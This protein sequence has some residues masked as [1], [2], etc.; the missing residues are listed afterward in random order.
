MF[1]PETTSSLG[2]RQ[3][4]KSGKTD[5]NESFIG[6]AGTNEK[7]DIP[8]PA[9]KEARYQLRVINYDTKMLKGSLGTKL[10]LVH[11]ILLAT[12]S[13]CK[14]MLQRKNRKISIPALRCIA[15]RVQINLYA[16]S[17]AMQCKQ[18]LVNQA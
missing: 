16:L 11:N 9:N 2:T 10:G 14:R 13:Q 7:A 4:W 5:I 6:K 1:V 8:A 15:T 12:G 18:N 17:V 3:L